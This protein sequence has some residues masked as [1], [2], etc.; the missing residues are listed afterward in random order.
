M[1]QPPVLSPGSDMLEQE[2][3]EV[4]LGCRATGEAS[5]YR[6]PRRVACGKSQRQTSKP[7]AYVSTVGHNK[8][9]ATAG[10]RSQGSEGV[11]YPLR[12][13][14]GFKHAAE[15]SQCLDIPELA[16]MGQPGEDDERGEDSQEKGMRK[17][18]PHN[19]GGLC[20]RQEGGLFIYL[21]RYY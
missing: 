20:Q 11:W 10:K 4:K 16:V 19:W 6:S 15:H 7:Q 18:D 5:E 1:F 8:I 2:P 12:P 9:G 14:L 3:E 17:G 13:R 21:L